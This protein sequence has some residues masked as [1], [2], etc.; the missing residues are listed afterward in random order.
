MA[1]P[2]FVLHAALAALSPSQ[3]AKMPKGGVVTPVH[4]DPYPAVCSVRSL[5]KIPAVQPAGNQAAA[6]GETDYVQRLEGN[7]GGISF[8]ILSDESV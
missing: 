5:S 6:L 1:T 8:S 4:K 2:E 7:G 3:R